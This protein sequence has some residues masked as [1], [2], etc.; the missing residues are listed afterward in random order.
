MILKHDSYKKDPNKEQKY[1]P[2]PK[3]LD[4]AGAEEDVPTARR[5]CISPQ[6][7]EQ[8]MSPCR[9]EVFGPRTPGSLHP[10]PSAPPACFTTS[11]FKVVDRI[12][13]TK[14]RKGSRRI[15]RPQGTVS[16]GKEAPRR[17]TP[18]SSTA[19]EGQHH[20]H[21]YHR[22][23]RPPQSAADGRLHSSYTIY[24]RD[25]R[26]PQPPA[27]GAAGGGRG[28]RRFD[29]SEVDLGRARK[30]ASLYCA[31]GG[32]GPR[33]VSSGPEQGCVAVFG[34]CGAFLQS[35]VSFW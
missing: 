30:I 31:G 26:L 7:L 35:D 33:S 22:P 6:A 15:R 5:C 34:A 9:R 24:N 27:A 20:L 19:E 8:E 32:D 17:R 28:T 1:N 3:Q 13:R 14:I 18:P 11:G 2:V 12:H 4:V 25:S 16:A 23:R 10:P 21:T 29:G